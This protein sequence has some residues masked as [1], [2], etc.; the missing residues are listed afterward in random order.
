VIRAFLFLAAISIG[1]SADVPGRFALEGT[2]VNSVTGEPLRHAA[3]ALLGARTQDNNTSLSADAGGH[4]T[5]ANLPAGNYTVQASK[6]G[7]A[8]GRAIPVA[9]SA[10]QSDINIKLQPFG[11]LTGTVVDDA[12]DPILNASVQLFKAAIQNGRRVIQPASHAMTNDLG[13]YH[14]ASLPAGR[15]YASATAQPEPDGTAYARTFYGGGPDIGSAA[16][17]ELDAGGSQRADIRMRPVQSF[18]VRGTIVNLPEHMQPYLNIARRGSVLAANEG[19]ATQVDPISG[20]FEF[21]G[22]TPGDWMVTAGCFDQGV[23]LFGTGEVVVSEA[24]AEGLTIS[25]GRADALSGTIHAEGQEAAKFNS[26]SLFVALQPA[27]DGSQP[28]MSAAFKEDGTFSL[29]GVQPGEYTLVTRSQAPWYIKSVRLSG[30]EISGQPFTVNSSGGDGAI[31]ITVAAGGAQIQGTV[32]EG[33][34]PVL[35]GFVLLLG[36]GPERVSGI[37]PAGKFFF[38]A[39]APGDYTA[40]AFPDLSQIEYT[41]PDVMQRF[42]AA[43]ISV[44]EGA[45]QQTELKLNRTVY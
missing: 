36:P 30:R 29:T 27:R 2:V 21:R 1:Y 23:Q 43:R 45:K 25:M 28:A 14:V 18:A 35:T 22:V 15:Y 32:V 16:P 26:H 5:I 38:G 31:E 13:E 24:D 3:I 42:S 11:R 4:F 40:Y 44:S 37:D 39:L 17:L 41:N 34:T 12:G 10:D 9:L 33:T 8:P 6:Q 20:K 7:F 19:H